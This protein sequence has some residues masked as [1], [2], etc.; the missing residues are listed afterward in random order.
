MLTK[1]AIAT[2]SRVPI[3][4][5]TS[6]AASSPSWASSVTS[7]PASSRPSASARPS[8][9][10]GRS[11]GDPPRLARQRRARRERLDA[12]AV[13]AVALAAAGRPCR[14]RRGRARR[15][16]RSRRGTARRGGSAHRRSRCRSSAARLAGAPRGAGPVLGQRGHVARRCRRTPA[17]RA[18]RPSRRRTA[19]SASGRLTA[20]TA[21]PGAL[22]DQARNSEADRLD[23]ATRRLAH[24][25]DR[26][27][28]DVEQ[29][30][31]V[32]TRH[33]ALRA[34]MDAESP[35]R[36][37][38][39]AAWS[40]PCRRRWCAAP[41]CRHYMQCSMPND[42]RTAAHTSSTAPPRGACGAPARR[43][44]ARLPGRRE[45]TRLR[46]ATGGKPRPARPA[47][48]RAHLAS[49][50]LKYL[51][52]AVVAWLLLSLVL[53]LVSAQIESGK[54]PASAQRRA[55][56]RART[57]SPRPTRSW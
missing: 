14:S 32:E 46:T 31:L 10:S 55:E 47:V 53:F 8:P 7:G 28:G 42:L 52:I 44:G 33:G 26:V 27:D 40:R 48:R 39:R 56:L 45:R 54:L 25:L 30:G 50:L 37:R 13:G 5:I 19:T 2:P 23:L 51:A 36:P 35:R 24:L 9:E 17:A 49:G 29:G 22:V 15:P 57:C 38:R 1:L 18:A 41:A 11:R 12:A 20:T 21:V 34:V 16:R 6:I 43:G 4:S 3:S